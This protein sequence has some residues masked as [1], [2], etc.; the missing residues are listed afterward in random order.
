[1]E[2]LKFGLP[3]DYVVTAVLPDGL[4]FFQGVHEIK[5]PSGMP[6]KVNVWHI[7]FNELG[8]DTGF[9]DYQRA[10]DWLPIIG[11]EGVKVQHKKDAHREWKLQHKINQSKN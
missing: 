8:P 4:N 5:L 6:V 3:K 10:H 2:K 9:F 1:M 11:M 7:D